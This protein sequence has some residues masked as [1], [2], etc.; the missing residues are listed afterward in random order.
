MS[1]NKR[2]KKKI[3]EVAKWIQVAIRNQH[4]GDLSFFFLGGGGDVKTV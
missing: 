1:E 2:F 4:E 3:D